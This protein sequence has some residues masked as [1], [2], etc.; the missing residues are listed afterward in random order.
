MG[1]DPEH[2]LVVEDAPKGLE[3]ARAA[4]C[5]TLAVMTTTAPEKLVADAVIPD[6]SAVTF[7]ADPEGIRVRLRAESR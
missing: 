7:T 6:L 3:A 2:C 1:V 5:F 4:G